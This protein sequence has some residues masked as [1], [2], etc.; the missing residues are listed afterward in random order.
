MCYCN[1]KEQ[2]NE[3]NNIKHTSSTYS[4]VITTYSLTGEFFQ[5]CSSQ[6]GKVV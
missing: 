2:S 3:L 1:S 4:Q 6:F 5:P